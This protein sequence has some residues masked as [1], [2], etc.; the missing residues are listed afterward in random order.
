MKKFLIESAV[1]GIILCASFFLV[2]L[3]AD[4]TTDPFY[5]RFTTKKQHSLI[6]GNSRAAQGIHP[7]VLNE[8][9]HRNDFFNYSF[10]L[11]TAPYGPVFLESISKK[12]DPETK[13]G[14]FILSVD[15]W[16]VSS[17]IIKPADSALFKES[18]YLLGKTTFVNCYPNIQYLW[19]S[20]EKSFYNILLPSKS[21]LIL[22][23]DGWLEVTM[24]MD[25]AR[26]SRNLEKKIKEYKKDNLPFFKF[27]PARLE[28]LIKTINFLKEHGQVYMVRLPIH[29]RMMEIENIL[30][31]DFD[32][33]IKQVSGVTNIPYLN[34]TY[35]N[36]SATFTD[37][38]H[39]YKVS[40]VEITKKIG[41]WI[42][43]LQ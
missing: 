28:Y 21:H 1:F 17:H 5:L 11:S 37:G 4:G 26:M 39:L 32:E 15:P 3:K 25:S 30:L 9:L 40:G 6:L 31:P 7:Y 19:T 8:V 16:S 38:N 2:F 22:H 24:K 14:V 18:K 36:E 35:L 20:Y 29:P 10:T 42:L 33:K 34:L 41:N 27:S 13:G 43:S 12:L 23:E